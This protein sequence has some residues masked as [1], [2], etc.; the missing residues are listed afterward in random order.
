MLI[1]D[2]RKAFL[3]SIGLLALGFGIV[4]IAIFGQSTGRMSPMP[5]MITL[6][7]GMYIPYVAFHTT[8]FERMIAAFRETGTIGYLLYLADAIGYLGYIGVMVFRN[9]VSGEVDFLKLL[10]WVSLTI[11]ILSTVMTL[12]LWRHFFKH[13]PHAKHGQVT[14]K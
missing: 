12:L 8:V 2:N 11:A 10:I 7:V 3:S 4:M 9:T 1:E 5:F 13:I 6:G 14:G